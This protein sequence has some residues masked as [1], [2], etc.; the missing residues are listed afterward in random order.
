MS[1]TLYK[2]KTS[3]KSLSESLSPKSTFHHF[4]KQMTFT[5]KYTKKT[6]ARTRTDTST[7]IDLIKQSKLTYEPLF[8]FN[9]NFMNLI[10]LQLKKKNCFPPIKTL[11]LIKSR[12]IIHYNSDKS[13]TTQNIK[14]KCVT[15]YN[16]KNFRSK[17]KT[18]SFLY[19]KGITF[20]NNIN[21]NLKLVYVNKILT[22]TS[23]KSIDNTHS[24][25]HRNNSIAINNIDKIKI[26][27]KIEQTNYNFNNSK[28]RFLMFHGRQKKNDNIKKGDSTEKCSKNKYEGFD[29]KKIRQYFLKK[30][31]KNVNIKMK[32]VQKDVEIAKNNLNLLFN[33]INNEIETKLNEEYK[34]Q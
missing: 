31:L 34:K 6:I 25:F 23:T 22:P 24:Y 12:P 7:I 20:G 11:A 17:H 9:K 4:P 3:K 30:K 32:S 16:Y 29:N 13:L 28:I 1:C 10:K 14:D 15:T 5:P 27:N 33:S 26:K 19:K 21:E 8:H 2:I 18:N